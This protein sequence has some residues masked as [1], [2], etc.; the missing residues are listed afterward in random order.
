M[1]DQLTAEQIQNWRRMLI[2]TLGPY[3]LIMPDAEVQKYRDRMQEH[4][5]TMESGTESKGETHE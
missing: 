5:N 1:T 3:A 2:S 4:V